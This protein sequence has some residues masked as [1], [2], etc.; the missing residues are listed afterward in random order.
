MTN[1]NQNSEEDLNKS[2]YTKTDNPEDESGNGN[3]LNEV[4]SFQC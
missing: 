2:F 4:V 1:H 3:K